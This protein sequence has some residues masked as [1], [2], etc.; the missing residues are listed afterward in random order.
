MQGQRSIA[1]D[2]S[3]VDAATIEK[4][5]KSQRSL[6]QEGAEAMLDNI[7]VRLKRQRKTQ[8]KDTDNFL[9]IR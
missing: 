1:L 6:R 7:V 9:S 4:K 8:H 2:E 5:L 3:G